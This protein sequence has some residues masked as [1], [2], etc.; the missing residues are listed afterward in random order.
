MRSLWILI[1]FF[2]SFWACK[3]PPKSSEIVYETLCSM[4]KNGSIDTLQFVLGD[5]TIVLK[6]SFGFFEPDSVSYTAKAEDGTEIV[7]KLAVSL[8][9]IIDLRGK[10][11]KILTSVNF[12]DFA[13]DLSDRENV[14]GYV[15]DQ[16]VSKD[17]IVNFDPA[18]KK[19]EI[20]VV[21]STRLDTVG[22]CSFT[23][24]GSK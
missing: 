2:F 15:I 4:S 1:L 12:G 24:V 19:E 3:N 23:K 17:T 16:I 18:T 22:T 9:T 14:K 13:L 20:S 5:S 10:D 21:E 7:G 11:G 6:N 8:A